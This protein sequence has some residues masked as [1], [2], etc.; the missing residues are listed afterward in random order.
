MIRSYNNF[1]K[2]WVNYWGGGRAMR[3][4]SGNGKRSGELTSFIVQSVV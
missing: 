1:K 4:V 3:I 2:Y